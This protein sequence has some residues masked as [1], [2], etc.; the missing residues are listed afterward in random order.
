MQIITLTSDFGYKDHSVAT[1]KGKLLSIDAALQIVDISHEIAP[2]NIEEAA[3][4]FKSAYREFPPGS[5]HLLSI[6]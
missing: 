2:Y 6:F 3:Y 4:I 5:I 1:L